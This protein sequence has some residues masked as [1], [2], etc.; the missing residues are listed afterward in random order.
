[1]PSLRVSC[2][3]RIDKPLPAFI[4]KNLPTIKAAATDIHIYSQKLNAGLAQEEDTSKV[5]WGNETDYIWWGIDLA[6]PMPLSP[7]VQDKLTTARDQLRKLKAYSVNIGLAA[8][9]GKYH[10]CLHKEGKS[11]EPEQEI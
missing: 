10:I 2:S 3:G 8:F 4:V 1:M 6:I 11:C 7:A 5:D 9:H